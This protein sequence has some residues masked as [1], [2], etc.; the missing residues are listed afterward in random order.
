MSEMIIF[1]KYQYNLKQKQ[2]V[3]LSECILSGF[4]FFEILLPLFPF[5][6]HKFTLHIAGF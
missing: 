5:I 4:Q 2:K 6:R 3:H 1:I